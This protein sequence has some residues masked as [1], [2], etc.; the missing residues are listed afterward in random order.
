MQPCH[1]GT[2]HANLVAPHAVLLLNAQ[3]SSLNVLASH[4]PAHSCASLP[5]ELPHACAWHAGSHLGKDKALAEAQ[6]ELR[7]L[8][9]EKAAWGKTQKGLQAQVNE[10]CEGKTAHCTQLACAPLILSTSLEPGYMTDC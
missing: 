9:Q 5:G 3:G 4:T 8:Q 7:S 6:K 2:N 10:R 1:H